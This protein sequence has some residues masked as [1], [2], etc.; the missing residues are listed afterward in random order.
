VIVI[1]SSGW[2]EYTLGGPGASAY[3]PYVLRDDVLVPAIVVY[4]V[5]KLA[6]RETT[7][8]QA[9]TVAA[10][11]KERTVVPLDDDLALRAAEASL[12]HKLAMADAI[13]YATAQQHGAELVTSDAD[14]D[15]LPGVSYIP[16]TT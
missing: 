7:E 3:S 12:E 5:Y 10:H 15:G 8:E 11:L 14:L 13:V 4:E 9:L 16:K 1:D 6:L 2:V